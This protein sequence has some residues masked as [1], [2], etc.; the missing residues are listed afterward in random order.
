MVAVVVVV[1]VKVVPVNVLDCEPAG[2][3]T[4]AGTVARPVLLLVSVTVRFTVVTPL[5]VTVPVELVP[6]FTVDG[7]RVKDVNDGTWT[8]K[9]ADRLTPL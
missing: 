3:V 6:P 2:I 5:R 1:R 8:V 9:V 4:L 7:F